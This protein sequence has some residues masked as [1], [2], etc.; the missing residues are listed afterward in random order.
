LKQP[1]LCCRTGM[2]TNASMETHAE[3]KPK[4]FGTAVEQF[5][6]IARGTI[7]LLYQPS[8]QLLELHVMIASGTQDG[9]TFL[10][11][12]NI[13]GAEVAGVAVI[14]RVFDRLE[15]RLDHLKGRVVAIPSLNPSGLLAGTRFPQFDNA[16]PNRQW[17][18]SRPEHL[19]R[20]HK[21]QEDTSDPWHELQTKV[22]EQEG[23]QAIA[24]KEVFAAITHLHPDCHVD[25]HTFSTLSIPFTFLDHVMYD[26]GGDDAAQA[27]G[28]AEKL[29]STT[30]AMVDATGLTVL[31][32]RAP[33]E[34]IKQKLHR[35]I[36]GAILNKL[37]VPSCT[38]EL[39]PMDFVKSQYRDAGI[40]ACENVLR[41]ASMLDEELQTPTRVKVLKFDRPHRYLNYPQAP[42]T[43]IVDIL[44]D[45]G[46][47]FE[48]GEEMLVIR[49]INGSVL[50]IV[51]AEMSGFV[52]GWYS[53]IAKYE[54]MVLGMVAV[55]SGQES[56]MIVPW[57]SLP[58]SLFQ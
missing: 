6:R 38:I 25:I 42:V 20:K 27:K 53:G 8:G 15:H 24:Y 54:G 10:L 29:Y 47:W 58:P 40:I 31:Q 55:P 2:N 14:H 13:H 5:G 30:K 16:D 37:R 9:P 41:W 7:P 28:E 50:H 18:D 21:E 43:G 22:D 56:A 19:K 36:S 34:Y 23:P 57:S 11:T 39:G 35:S 49:H 45:P 12:G 51:K 32:E 26:D 4:S 48:K 52:I 1:W 46:D 44:K 17:P 3:R 33:R